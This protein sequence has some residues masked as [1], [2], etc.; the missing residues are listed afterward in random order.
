MPSALSCREVYDKTMLVFGENLMQ[1]NIAVT[2][3]R[4]HGEVYG[5]QCIGL[6]FGHSNSPNCEIWP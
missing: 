2:V 5:V 1:K 3:D 6:L 4:G